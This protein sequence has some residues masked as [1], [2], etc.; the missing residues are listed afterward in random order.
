MGG[1]AFESLVCS[2][3]RKEGS[4]GS[5]S[6]SWGRTG[7]FRHVTHALGSRMAKRQLREAGSDPA[8]YE[9]QAALYLLAAARERRLRRSRSRR[10]MPHS[11]LRTAARL[12]S[13]SRWRDG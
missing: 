3:L 9:E 6:H 8:R 1:T 10:S 12:C 13:T 5:E 11:K 4:S 2:A 7:G